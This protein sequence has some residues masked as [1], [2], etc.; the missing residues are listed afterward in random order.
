MG[1]KVVGITMG[2]FHKVS[3]KRGAYFTLKT[4]DSTLRYLIEETYKRQ[5]TECIY[6]YLKEGCVVGC[7]PTCFFLSCASFSAVAVTLVAMC[8]QLGVQE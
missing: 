8:A 3:S 4:K 6:F 1:T 5:Y 2:G 7:R